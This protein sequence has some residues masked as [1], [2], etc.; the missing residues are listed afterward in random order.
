MRQFSGKG[1]GCLGDRIIILY[2]YDCL[3]SRRGGSPL[4]SDCRPHSGRND[5]IKPNERVAVLGDSEVK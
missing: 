3:R 4:R 2:A 5:V 1:N